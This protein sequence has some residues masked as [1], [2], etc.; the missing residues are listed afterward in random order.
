MAAGR[1]HFYDEQ[2]LR[3]TVIFRHDV[4]DVAGVG[5]LAARHLRMRA[6]RDDLRLE[7]LAARCRADGK[8]QIRSRRCLPAAALRH[9]DG[10]GLALERRHAPAEFAE[11]FA[12][13]GYLRLT[14]DQH[15]A[16]FLVTGL[17]FG[18]FAGLQ[19]F[20][21]EADIGPPGA[22]RRHVLH[23]AR[24]GLRFDEQLGHVT[25]SLIPFPGRSERVACPSP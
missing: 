18:R 11:A 14:G 15:E 22:L 13:N 5:A 21:R 7:A 1:N 20:K 6:R 25:V 9:I 4:G 23:Q 19:P 10:I 17:A 2:R 3:R 16:D 12:V 8:I 24:F